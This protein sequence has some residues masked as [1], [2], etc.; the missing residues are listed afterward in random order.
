M[1]AIK[2]VEVEIIM[3]KQEISLLPQAGQALTDEESQ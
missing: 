3:V 1:K 2:T